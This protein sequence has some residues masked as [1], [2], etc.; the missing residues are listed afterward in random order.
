MNVKLSQH[1]DSLDSWNMENG[2]FPREEGEPRTEEG[3]QE[4]LGK[5]L[6]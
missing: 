6:V 4:W 2:S 5:T 3:T 1:V